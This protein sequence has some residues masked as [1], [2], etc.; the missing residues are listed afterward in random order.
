VI[1]RQR[2]TTVV[3][4]LPHDRVLEVRDAVDADVGGLVALYG[5]LS[6]EDRYR[7]F[8]SMYHPDRAFFEH[9]ATEADRGGDEI[10]AVVSGPTGVELVGE[11]GWSPVPGDEG[12]LS[13]AVARD[14]RGWLGAVLLDELL[15]RAHG[16][17][18]AHLCA[19]VLAVNTPMIA[20]LRARGA[21]RL[22]QNDWTILRLRVATGQR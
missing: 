8:F 11:A 4:P 16:R 5:E 18:V 9:M 7:R 6:P 3:V 17:G 13:M 2:D 10:V 12:E 14:W 20:L 21:E 19:D 1:E 15:R 22:I